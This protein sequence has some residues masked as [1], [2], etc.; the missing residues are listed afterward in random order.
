MKGKIIK[1]MNINFYNG[2]KM[3]RIIYKGDRWECSIKVPEKDMSE[4]LDDIMSGYMDLIAEKKQNIAMQQMRKE[5]VEEVW[6]EPIKR[7]AKEAIEDNKR[8]QKWLKIKELV[9]KMKVITKQEEAEQD[10]D[11]QEMDIDNIKFD[12]KMVDK[13]NKLTYFKDE[14]G[15]REM[16]F[17][18]EKDDAKTYDNPFPKDEALEYDVNVREKV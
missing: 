14:K 4:F 10:I 18:W 7:I 5:M 17:K 3:F 9:D 6:G 11:E 1:N 13:I 2:E 12:K 15:E 8:F 16:N